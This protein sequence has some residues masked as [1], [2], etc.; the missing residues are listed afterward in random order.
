MRCSQLPA[1]RRASAVSLGGD[2]LEGVLGHLVN[3]PRGIEQAR[4]RADLGQHAVPRLAVAL[5]AVEFCPGS[6][7]VLVVA[8]ERLVGLVRDAVLQHVVVEDADQAVAAADAGVEEGERLAGLEGL[9]PERHLAELDR[10]RVAIDAMDAA[11]D[12]L[13]E[14]VL[15]LDLGGC[16]G[17]AELGDA[18]GGAAGGA[19]Q[20]VAGAA[21]GVEDRQAQDRGDRVR[22]VARLGGVQDRVE[23]GIQQELHERFGG[24]VGAGLLALVAAGLAAFGEGEG[25]GVGGGARA[26]AR[27]GPRR[28]S[29]APRSPCRAS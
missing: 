22:G 13:A 4:G 20:E 11:G 7:G 6:G 26:S 15:E 8:G 17:A 21:G 10:E 5:A 29:P 14:R 24:V 16:A 12:D 9:D 27:A 19:E 25:A 28:P 2:L 23:G 3:F 1:C 18:G